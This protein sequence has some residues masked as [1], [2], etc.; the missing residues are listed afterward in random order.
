MKEIFIA[1]KIVCKLLLEFVNDN[2]LLCLEC[3]KDICSASYR[4][5]WNGVICISFY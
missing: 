5:L 3:F 2:F 4:I 1:S